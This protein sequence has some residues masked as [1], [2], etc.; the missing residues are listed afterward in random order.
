MAKKPS[1]NE[2]AAIGLLALHNDWSN[3]QIAKELGIHRGTLYRMPNYLEI[4]A[5]IK[6]AGLREIPRGTR[7]VDK[8]DRKRPAG[9][10]AW[11]EEP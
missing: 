11:I 3:E 10:E 8:A 5:R 9:I 7:V 1:R 6:E 4:A 2:L